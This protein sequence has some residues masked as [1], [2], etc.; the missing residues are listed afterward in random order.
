MQRERILIGIDE[1]GEKVVDSATTREQIER[2]KR[3]ECA[4]V[5][6]GEPLRWEVFDD[7]Q[8]PHTLFQ[9]IIKDRELRVD[10]GQLMADRPPF[11]VI[12]AVG[13][14]AVRLEYYEGHDALSLVYDLRAPELAGKELPPYLAR[15][16][17]AYDPVKFL[18]QA[19][20]ELVERIGEPLLREILREAHERLQRD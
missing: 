9:A 14:R 18:K 7:P 12:T 20:P 6:R 19:F 17:Y 16:P 1:R 4:L 8:N 5:H 13:G 2:I 3:L 11:A 10:Q 15:D